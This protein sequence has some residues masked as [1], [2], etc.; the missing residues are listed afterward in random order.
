[1]N[2]LRNSAFLHQNF[3]RKAAKLIKMHEIDKRAAN[4]KSQIG[5]KW[6]LFDGILRRIVAKMAFGRL[7]IRFPVID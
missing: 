7:E 5:Q 2:S 6:S 4:R 1:M 3:D